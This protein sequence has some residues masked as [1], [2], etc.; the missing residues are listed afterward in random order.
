MKPF[1]KSY[2]EK[3]SIMRA[4]PS[5]RFSRLSFLS[6]SIVFAC[7]FF[8]MPSSAMAA[9]C[10]MVT[11]NITVSYSPA[12]AYTTSSGSFTRQNPFYMSYGDFGM[13]GGGELGKR[14]MA[15]ATV[16]NNG[17]TGTVTIPYGACNFSYSG[18]PCYQQTTAMIGGSYI[19]LYF[20]V[21]SY[22]HARVE[23]RAPANQAPI[24]DLNS[25][26]CDAGGITGWAHDRDTQASIDT[27]MYI[28]GA[29]VAYLPANQYR[30]DLCQ[31]GT[32][33]YAYTSSI[34][35]SYKNGANHTL[36]IYAID[37]SG[38][39]PNPVIGNTT[40]NCQ[41]PIPPQPTGLSTSCNA[42]GTQATFSWNA[43][44]GSTFYYYRNNSSDSSCAPGF[45][46]APGSGCYPNPDS[47]AGTSV[48][49]PTVPG[50]AYGWWV[51]AANGGGYSNASYGSVTCPVPPPDLIGYA[52]SAT[53][54]T[55]N[56]T[57]TLSGSIYNAGAGPAQNV[58]NFFQVC[59]SAV[60][61]CDTVMTNTVGYLASGASAGVS[62]S[63]T[64]S[65]TNRGLYRTCANFNASHQNVVTESNYGNNCS[66]W[67][68]FTAYP[69]PVPPDLTPGS[70]PTVYGTVGSPITLSGTVNNSGGPTNAGFQNFF[71]TNSN[72]S[73][74]QSERT[75]SPAS[76]SLNAGGS[77]SFSTTFPA[78][79]F[80]APGSY[81]YAYCVDI[82]NTTWAGTIAES[83]EGNNCV[84]G[85]IVMRSNPVGNFEAMT[86]DAGGMLGWAYDADVPNSPIDVHFYI[87]GTLIGSVS[88]N[89]YR[90]DLGGYGNQNHGFSW[91]LPQQ[92]KNGAS[93]TVTAYAIDSNGVFNPVIGSRSVTCSAPPT[94]TGVTAS[95][96]AAGTQATLSWNAS[97]GA[98]SYQPRF[99]PGQEGECSSSGWNLWPG[100]NLTCLAPGD[101]YTGTSKVMNIIPNKGYALWVHAVNGNGVS[102]GS[103]TYN[104]SCAG[105][106][107]LTTGSVTPTSA[108]AGTATT[109][110]ATV[111]NTGAAIAGPTQTR[112]QSATS[113]G[114]AGAATIG[115]VATAGGF[116][117]TGTRVVSIAHTFASAGTSYIRACADV[118]GAVAEGNEGNNCGPWTAVSVGPAIPPA[119]TGLN[120]SCNAAGTSAT[121]SWNATPG[122]TFYYPRIYTSGPCSAGWVKSGDNTV[123]YPNPDNFAGTSM[124]FTTT[125]GQSYGWFVH[126]ANSTGYGPSTSS[127]FTCTGQ[128]DITAATSASP[129]STLVNQGVTLFGVVYNIGTANATSFPSIAQVCTNTSCSSGAT[130]IATSP[131]GTLATGASR[132]VSVTY[133]PPATGSY[134]Y[135]I[136]GNMNTSGTLIIT[137]GNYGNNCGAWQTL[138]VNSVPTVT[139]TLTPNS[140]AYGGSTSVSWSSTAATSCTGTNV[141]T[142]GATSGSAT[143]SNIT[144]ATT[145][146]VDCTGP[147]GSA[148]DA[149]TITVGAQPLPDLTATTGSTIATYSSNAITLTGTVSNAGNAAASSFPN[150]AQV[151]NDGSICNTFG[152]TFAANTVGSLAAGASTGLSASYTAPASGNYVYRFCADMNTAGTIILT[153][154]NY[155]NNCG[156][157][158]TLTV[159]PGQPTGLS[160]SCNAAGTQATM[161]WNATPSATFYYVRVRS[162]DSVCPAGWAGN[163]GIGCNPNPDSVS[164]T[165]T[166]YPSVPGRTYDWWV[167][168]ANPS[169]GYSPESYGAFTCT[170]QAELSASSV[171]PTSAVA[172]SATIF[173]ST[174]ANT[175]TASAGATQTRFQ[176]ATSAGGAG[177]ATISDAA[178]A[179]IAAGA[180]R[181]V[182]ASYTPASAGTIWIRACAD[183]AGAVAEGNEANNCSPWTAVTVS[184]PP[185]PDITAATSG[186]QSATQNQAIV[187]GGSVTNAGNAAAG[188]FPNILQVCDPVSCSNFY[189]VAA[190]TNVTSLAVGASQAISASYTPSTAGNFV[191][192]MCGNFNTAT[193]NIIT[194]SNYGNNCGAWQ[195]LTIQSDI[196][197][198]PTGLNSSCNA[199]GTLATMNW[200]ATPNATFYYVRVSSSDTVCPA[201]WSGNPAVACNPNP[202]SV[203]GTSTTYPTVPGRT[204]NWWV[205][206]ANATG[207]GQEAYGAYTCAGQPELTAGNVSPTTAVPGTPNTFSVTLANSGTGL[208]A[209]SQTLFQRATSAGGANATAIGQ[210]A[211]PSIP[212]GGSVTRS[213]SYTPP[214][215]QAFFMRVCAD[216]TS[217]VTEPN[218]GNNCGAWIQVDANLVCYASPTTI[219]S[220][221]TVTYSTNS[222]SDP[223]Y[224]WVSSDSA[225][226][227]NNATVVRTLVTPGAY[228][229]T[230]RSANAP[231][232]VSCP[233]VSVAASWCTVSSTNVSIT[234]SRVRVPAGETVD[235]DWNA[236]GVNGQDASCTV[237]GPN[238]GGPGVNSIGSSVSGAPSCSLSGS[239]EPV[240]ATQSEYAIECAGVRD[241]VIVN[242]IPGFTEF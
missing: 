179:T 181:V 46:G 40:F 82:A 242:V 12:D 81:E 126:A 93:Q 136:C 193:V 22:V 154:S 191:Y 135:R 220:G 114:G 231:S 107:E 47:V 210:V 15:T 38:G 92:Y 94:P 87:G 119:P 207:P 203:S 196:P 156:A 30:G 62:G 72:G 174:I 14:W 161:S 64:L 177:A 31:F 167:H 173:S 17:Q 18:S 215:A 164:G 37:S 124:P 91:S 228:T 123:C 21:Q 35:A 236:S 133:A 100:D 175:G 212:A 227:G 180:N 66:A 48:S 201:G 102:A 88:A 1:M 6:V 213:I 187:L 78:N 151:C 218:E 168:A 141:S 138:T 33:N 226:L 84:N 146:R 99:Y 118:G 56:Q 237:T 112:F 41:P 170:G 11:P 169:T 51:H 125:P 10:N 4:A 98:T 69:A 60:T 139:V 110:T 184:P 159:T 29:L 58:P 113:A 197:P 160:S 20:E 188:S 16:T 34:P 214:A 5:L 116:D 28:D 165:S 74:W 86:C 229:M 145:Y 195:A 150:I 153:E 222:P 7:A 36:T 49:Y 73:V 152:V 172:G 204:Y 144:A 142:G 26:T 143:V 83:N 230:V 9:A 199:A 8:I 221:E 130:N 137:E 23:C 122:A 85:T 111:S 43:S 77:A 240:I 186:A 75:A 45:Q 89:Q 128:P 185:A 163:P 232:A 176:S 76:G 127:N 27:H 192:R 105:Q 121:V 225:S 131:E 103:P 44:P 140:V 50:R 234:A 19:D 224:T 42:A 216:T 147:G 183:N 241:S 39:G 209:A 235:I 178:T 52:G 115:D 70:A 63:F 3:H 171:T 65:S 233:M 190:A 68:T 219:Q 109:Y 155:G 54:G 97:P 59:D 24:G 238:V 104:F 67:Q 148:W 13:Q 239:V 206:G 200:N 53:S 166:T 202:D 90:G 25:A 120:A 71:V 80:S 217:V 32:C 134:V 95:C 194:E 129:A 208:A 223:P 189:A 106:A 162:A 101:S 157:W 182:T 132:G 57:V 55:V 205:H 198:Q 108:V 2:T 96:N 158:Q 79:T 149:K 211:T 117:P 61:V